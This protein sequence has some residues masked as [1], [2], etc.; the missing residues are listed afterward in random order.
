MDKILIVQHNVLHW[1]TRKFNL[2][3]TYLDIAPHIILINSHGLKEQETIKIHGYTT[4]IINTTQENNDRSAVLIRNNIKHKLDDN[5]VTDILEVII[6]TDIGEIGI[7]T[8]YL[9]PRRAYLAY[10]DFHRLASKYRPTYIIGDLNATMRS[11]GHNTSN[12]VGR[13]LEKIF[14]KGSL[15]H[16]G[17]KFTTYHERRSSTTPDII[18]GNNSHP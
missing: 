10:P 11:Q 5:Y 14:N 8:T 15:T 17:P 2:T 13:G 7:A 18:L 9:P 3:Q 4:Y 6:K 12:R 1:N 16:L